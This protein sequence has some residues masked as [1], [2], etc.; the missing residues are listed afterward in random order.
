MNKR[1][2]HYFNQFSMNLNMSSGSLQATSTPYL[3]PVPHTG[4]VPQGMLWMRGSWINMEALTAVS[5]L[6]RASHQRQRSR[7]KNLGRFYDIQLRGGS[8]MMPHRGTGGGVWETWACVC[9]F[10]ARLPQCSRSTL[11][12]C[13]V[14]DDAHMWSTAIQG[15]HSYAV[16]VLQCS[17]YSIKPTPCLALWIR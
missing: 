16:F 12:V 3:L 11:A 6:R 14:F 7:W 13:S 17:Q 2:Q 5:L 1:K 8:D 10:S 15:R 9:M 4:S